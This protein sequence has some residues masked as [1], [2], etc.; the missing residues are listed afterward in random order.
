SGRWVVAFHVLDGIGGL[1]VGSTLMESFSTRFEHQQAE[2][3]LSQGN[4]TLRP[5]SH[6]QT[7]LSCGPSLPKMAVDLSGRWYNQYCS[8][9]QITTED[10]GA[11]SGSYLSTT[12]GSGAFN[13]TGFQGT[14]NSS[15]CGVP[16][17]IGIQWHPSNQG[18]ETNESKYW[19]SSYSGL[20]LPEQIITIDGQ[21]QRTINASFELLN[22]LI[23]TTS[24]QTLPVYGQKGLAML[25]ES[26]FFTRQAPDYCLPS[27]APEP[28]AGCLAAPLNNVALGSWTSD[29]GTLTIES[30]DCN[31]LQGIFNRADGDTFLVTGLI[32]PNKVRTFNGETVLQS[33]TLALRNDDGEVMSLV[34]AVSKD[35]RNLITWD[36][37]I[38]S[39]SYED[40]YTANSVSVTQWN[41]L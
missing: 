28:V 1:L 26:L 41:K 11:L 20:F 33:L 15:T 19:V 38:T 37:Q 31:G 40:R 27:N 6:G 10:S 35:Q 2:D 17:S 4:M 7:T 8:Q 24:Q 22:E 13:L 29:L 16:V 18:A 30:A 32:D 34:G 36:T 25:P 9:I 5:N 14:N 39:T 3:Q 12:G 23:P 21:S